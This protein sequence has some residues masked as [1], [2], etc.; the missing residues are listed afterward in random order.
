MDVIYPKH[1][2]NMEF[3]IC[4]TGNEYVGLSEHYLGFCDAIS[5]NFCG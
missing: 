3:T 4:V 2:W 1:Y 5:G